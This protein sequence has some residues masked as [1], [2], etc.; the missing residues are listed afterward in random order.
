VPFKLTLNRIKI[1]PTE[2]GKSAP[3]HVLA[4]L[5]KYKRDFQIGPK[6]Q[7]WLAIDVDRW[8]TAQLAQVSRAATQSK[9]GLAISAPCFE[10]WLYLHHAELAYQPRLTTGQ[11]KQMLREKLGGYDPSNLRP[12]D[13]E[14]RVENAIEYAR[15]IDVPTHAWPNGNGSK[16]FLLTEQI[17]MLTALE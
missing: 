3:K 12:E 16:L 10:A 13:F 8:P 1:L 4:R 2:N 5:K 14:G 11:I 15:K 9:F 17:L 6:D 7:L